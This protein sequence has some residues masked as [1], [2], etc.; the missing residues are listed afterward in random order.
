[1][2]MTHSIAE[3]IADWIET[4]GDPAAAAVWQRCMD[5]EILIT[6]T[7]LFNIVVLWNIPELNEKNKPLL[8]SLVRDGIITDEFYP[9]GK[10]GEVF[11]WNKSN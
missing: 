4:Y 9:I 2:S 5:A 7:V 11:Y 1:M 3:S 6:K 10:N 8:D